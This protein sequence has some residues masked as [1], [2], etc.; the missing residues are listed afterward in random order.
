MLIAAGM[1]ALTIGIMSADR[2]MRTKPA[3][4]KGNDQKP[5]PPKS[6]R[7]VSIHN[8]G[9]SDRMCA[10]Q[11]TWP[12]APPKPEPVPEPPRASRAE[13][14][15][16]TQQGWT[17]PQEPPA[18]P[19]PQ[20]QPQSAPAREDRQN[21]AAPEMDADAVFLHWFALAVQPTHGNETVSQNDLLLSYKTYCESYGLK[22]LNGQGF[23]RLMMQQ[24]EAARCTLSQTGDIVGAVLKG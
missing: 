1:G 19:S 15:L 14:M 16:M 13:R 17:P 20:P 24:V 11:R 2:D 7:S 9:R 6:R 8:S 5:T 22:M 10:A 23:V 18:Q 3:A 21:A 12:P 4:R